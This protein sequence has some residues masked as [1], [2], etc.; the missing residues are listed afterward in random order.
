MF[1]ISFPSAFKHV[2][3]AYAATIITLSYFFQTTAEPPSDTQQ[4]R[5]AGWD[6]KTLQ[7]A[8]EM[9]TSFVA[10]DIGSEPASAH[11]QESVMIFSY[12]VCITSK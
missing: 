2:L 4:M 12:C 9:D 8:A 3:V 11:P 1:L 5:E 7:A 10:S 6:E